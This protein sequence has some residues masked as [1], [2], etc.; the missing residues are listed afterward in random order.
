MEYYGIHY[1]SVIKHRGIKSQKWGVRRYQNPDAV[2]K[3]MQKAVHK[4]RGEKYGKANRWRTDKGIG[5][6]SEKVHESTRQK[7]KSWETGES[8]KNAV[9][10][11]DKPFDQG[12]ISVNDYDRKYATAWDKAFED[13]P[14]RNV[15]VMS[16]KKRQYLENYVE[17][18]T[19]LLTMAYLK[20]LGF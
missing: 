10:E 20:D 1:N 17:Q 8:Y 3:Q 14:A 11:T 2:R 13:A 12:K 19:R 15:Y 16:G 9:R 18:T 5:T 4:A 7:E 6:E